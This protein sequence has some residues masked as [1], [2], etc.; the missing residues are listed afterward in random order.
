M[1]PGRPGRPVRPGGDDHRSGARAARPAMPRG[2]GSSCLA[3]SAVPTA[4]W[5]ATV[6]SSPSTRPEPGVVTRPMSSPACG[7]TICWTVGRSDFDHDLERVG[8]PGSAGRRARAERA[9]VSAGGRRISA[10]VDLVAVP[11][12]AGGPALVSQW[13]DVTE[14]GTT[15]NAAPA[16][17]AA[18]G[19]RL[20]RVRAG[21]DRRSGGRPHRGR[22]PRGGSG[23]RRLCGL[24]SRGDDP[25]PGVHVAEPAAGCARPG[26]AA[27]PTSDPGRDRARWPGCPERPPGDRAL[28]RPGGI[29][30]RLPAQSG[31]RSM[32]RLERGDP[33]GVF[34]AVAGV[35]ITYRFAGS[36][37]YTAQDVASSTS[38]GCTPRSP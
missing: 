12:V 1:R 18:R 13:T 36:P 34:G 30:C 24:P 14:S 23:R 31:V 22:R 32:V 16:C 26:P 3:W 2:P 37:A 25:A 6:P 38:S 11:A 10:I 7:Y 9:V 27:P 28:R 5:A 17:C 21:P 15:R 8:R 4:V 20:V 19:D 29:T 35:V 33:V